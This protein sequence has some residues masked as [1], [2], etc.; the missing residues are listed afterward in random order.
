MIMTE[1]GYQSLRAP[2]E[3]FL[4]VQEF[5]KAMESKARS[6]DVDG[7]M[8]ASAAVHY[9]EIEQLASEVMVRELRA[10]VPPQILAWRKASPGIGE[11]LLAKLLGIIGDPYIAT[12]MR[13]Q[14][15]PGAA[16]GKDDPKRI[17]VPDGEPHARNVGR[18]WALC[19]YGDPARRRRTGMSAADAAAL[20]NPWAKATLRLLA[21]SCIKQAHSPYRPVYDRAREHYAGRMHA[22]PCP[23]CK[24][25]SK[26]GEPW[27]DGHQHAAA[28]RRVAKEILR[29]LWEA[30]REAHTGI[31][32][33]QGLDD[34]HTSAA[35]GEQA[36]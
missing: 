30:A 1:K 31:P 35:P 26:T 15:R 12:P 6:G 24:G 9:R 29:D 17:L 27:K 33:G 20:G 3:M 2:A 22:A 32:R 34:A 18:L 8:V 16:G 5:R 13:W 25:S 23:Q 36:A 11:H 10:T 4:D 21:E 14:D 19:G 7:V 28:L